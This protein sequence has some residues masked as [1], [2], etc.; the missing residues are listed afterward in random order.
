MRTSNAIVTTALIGLVLG[1]TS[2]ASFDGARSPDTAPLGTVAVSP[3]D[4]ISTGPTLSA[5]P[6]AAA[7]PFDALRSGNQ[8]LRD[9]RIDQGLL[10]LE[11]AAER[12][13]PGALWKLG[14]IYA[15]GD[16][17]TVNHKRAYEYF[18]NLTK[19]HAYDSPGTPHARFVADAFVALGHFYLVGIPETEVK[20]DPAVAYGM[21]RHAASYF[22]DPEAQFQVGRM[23]LE[24]IGTPK[25]TVQASRW[26]RLAADRGQR[27]AQALLGSI[28]FKGTDVA[29]QAAMGLFWL[30]VAKDAV[31]QGGSGP[32]DQWIADTYSNAFAQATEEE[33]ETA[34]GYLEGWMRRRR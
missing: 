8:M 3:T 11:Y 27:N 21:F 32:D 26:L 18:R 10:A 16:G 28:L 13:V 5:A 29:R 22:G 12:G 25:D 9:G 33:R 19:S 1:L 15:D 34:L 23:H 24:G 6:P 4:S 2:A 20:L 7:T 31:T 17:V 14:R 30:T